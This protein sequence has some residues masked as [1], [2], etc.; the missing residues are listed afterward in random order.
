MT[1]ERSG[2]MSGGGFVPGPA[3]GSS[4]ESRSCDA[5]ESGGTA[6][7]VLPIREIATRWGDAITRAPL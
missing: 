6:R 2:A 1:R 5:N 4:L 3:S 7:N